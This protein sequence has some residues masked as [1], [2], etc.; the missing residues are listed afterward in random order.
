MTV[1]IHVLHPHRSPPAEAATI[2]LLSCSNRGTTRSS[3][4][5]DHGLARRRILKEEIGMTVT[6][7]ISGSDHVP[8][9]CR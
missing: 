1:P 6:V 7:K 2:Q 4:I 5:S 8:S 9:H 3:Q